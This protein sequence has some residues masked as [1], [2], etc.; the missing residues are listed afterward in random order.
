MKDVRPCAASIAILSFILLAA[1]CGG[2][3][4]S[5]GPT[6]A[7]PTPAAVC[8]Q[9]PGG[10]VGLTASGLYLFNSRPGVATPQIQEFT[11]ELSSGSATQVRTV[12]TGAGLYNLI[13]TANGAFAYGLDANGNLWGYKVNPGN[14]ELTSLGI[15]A[16]GLPSGLPSST[17]NTT[18]TIYGSI[19]LWVMTATGLLGDQNTTIEF[20][21]NS[22][23]TLGSSTSVA[24][25]GY[26]F[27]PFIPPSSSQASALPTAL[28]AD[29]Q[30]AQGAFTL[31]VYPVDMNGMISGT[32]IQS[33]SGAPPNAASPP[34]A[35]AY[36]LAGPEGPLDTF[37]TAVNG[38]IT[39]VSSATLPGT[40]LAGYG[41]LSP[42]PTYGGALDVY[43]GDFSTLLIFPVS[44]NGVLG[45][46]GSTT[47]ACGSFPCVPQFPF[48]SK[49]TSASDP[50]PPL[51][52]SLP[53]V[54]MIPR[55]D[56]SGTS[57]PSTI[58]EF[59]VNSDG[60]INTSL[61]G[62]V[63]APSSIGGLVPGQGPYS[64]GISGAG[65]L[66]D[67]TGE[68]YGYRVSSTGALTALG[69]FVGPSISGFELETLAP[70]PPEDFTNSPVA[71]FVQNYNQD[72]APPF[73]NQDG[74]T[75]SI[76]SLCAQGM[77]SSTTP[78]STL[79]VPFAAAETYVVLTNGAV[80]AGK[81]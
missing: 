27:T 43:T 44:S 11:T 22:D 72:F 19:T 26:A 17:S 68:I 69:S 49:V 52:T 36:A 73:L 12:A 3:S 65:G 21:I 51:A 7:S 48:A 64:Y 32:P 80:L 71:L 9:P 2:D 75:V 78:T 66:I 30:N 31:R 60:S 81:Y 18:L 59:T 8:S 42:V 46:L 47:L 55:G 33:L 45:S 29:D 15:L 35:F 13:F 34:N 16:S 39:P 38:T 76:Y 58:N 50:L 63:S 25:I 24:L 54:W 57:I 77:P 6:A 41:I 70:F 37:A 62:S 1:G 56:Q 14:G 4:S 61:A 40:S 23:G 67:F 53:S 28:W 10:T 5:S 74:G 79:T 20:P